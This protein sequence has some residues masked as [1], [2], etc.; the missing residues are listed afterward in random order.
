MK[1]AHQWKSVRGLPWPYCKCC[2]LLRL[3]NAA[4]ELAVSKGCE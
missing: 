1:R 4:T 2:G 3:R